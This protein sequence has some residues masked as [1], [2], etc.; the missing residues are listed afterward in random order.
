MD[1]LIDYGLASL[2]NQKGKV[3]KNTFSKLLL[4]PYTV[5]DTDHIYNGN[6]NI[7]EDKKVVEEDINLFKQM[8]FS[9][10]CSP[11]D[12]SNE[13]NTIWNKLP[14]QVVENIL[15]NAIGSSSNATQ[16]YHSVMQICYKFQI[17]KQKRKRVL[18]SVYIDTH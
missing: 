4:N 7:T 13:S 11:N 16:D 18:P 6:V 15:L 12:E 14:D 5:S 3:L 1:N 9:K 8:E 17:I 2:K 10:S